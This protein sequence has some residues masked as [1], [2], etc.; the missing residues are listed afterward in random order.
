MTL[1]PEAST[2][3]KN[4]ETSLFALSVAELKAFHEEFKDL[5]KRLQNPRYAQAREFE[6][7]KAA[8]DEEFFEHFSLLPPEQAERLRELLL[9]RRL[10]E[11][12]Y[13]KAQV[14]L[15]KPKENAKVKY[16]IDGKEIE[17]TGQGGGPK[18]IRALLEKEGWNKNEKNFKARKEQKETILEKYRV[19]EN[20]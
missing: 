10:A 11:E 20:G 5:I 7:R 4:L 18:E 13:T 9:E 1:S 19:K 6:E 3:L 12:K 2:I 16:L 14:D 15:V 17:W 8:I